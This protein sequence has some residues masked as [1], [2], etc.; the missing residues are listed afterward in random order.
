[1]YGGDPVIIQ[2]PRSSDA[3][4][5]PSHSLIQ[6]G[7]QSAPIT[8][9]LAD[10][11][12]DGGMPVVGILAPG[13]RTRR[14]PDD[15]GDTLFTSAELSSTMP[16]TGIRAPEGD[17]WLQGG[18]SAEWELEIGAPRSVALAEDGAVFAVIRPKGSAGTPLS[19]VTFA[20]PVVDGS[21]ILGWGCDATTPNGSET[22]E[23]ASFTGNYRLWDGTTP[24]GIPTT[25][26]D[27]VALTEFLDALG[28]SAG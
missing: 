8:E 11:L 20:A 4:Q 17:V 25:G 15:G 10:S 23:R 14:V 18:I 27:A 13:T 9:V 26:G 28:L 16:L 2:V 3:S 6:A 7:C 21:V 5:E 1:M 19:W 22:I 12:R 24:R